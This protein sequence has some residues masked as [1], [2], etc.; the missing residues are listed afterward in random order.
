MR[1]ERGGLL[2]TAM[3]ILALGAVLALA[4]SV[5]L[6]SYARVVASDLALTRA[7]YISYSALNRSVYP[8]LATDPNDSI[9]CADLAEQYTDIPMASGLYTLEGNTFEPAA[10]PLVVADGG[11]QTTLC[12]EGDASGYAAQGRVWIDHEAIDYAQL[13]CAVDNGCPQGCSLSVLVRG[14]SGTVE[15]VHPV[16]SI[17]SQRQCRVRAPARMAEAS[18]V[19]AT[20]S[21]IM[22]DLPVAYALSGTGFW[23]W[24]AGQWMQADS[25][26]AT[27]SALDGL[28][29]QDIWAVGHA[30]VIYHYNGQQWQLHSSGVLTDLY[31]IYC[32]NSV[33]C[34]AVGDAGT[35][36][37]WQG[38]QWVTMASNQDPS[39]PLAI[40]GWSL[41][42][43]HCTSA[44][45]WV[46][47][48]DSQGQA[49]AIAQE[50]DG[51]WQRS[52]NVDP[53]VPVARYR[54]IDC[55]NDYLCYTVGDQ[56]TG[57]FNILRWQGGDWQVDPTL[58][59]SG[60]YSEL[61]AIRCFSSGWCWAVGQAQGNG[62]ILQYDGAS[63]QHAS[64]LHPALS[65]TGRNLVALS[66]RD[67]EHCWAADA[68][69]DIIVHN[70]N[71]WQL[72]ESSMPA[73]V[74]ALTHW[75]YGNQALSF[76][77]YG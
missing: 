50:V 40:N 7:D 74:V 53:G 69:G 49:V 60:D 75:H 52:L 36:L 21:A 48:E 9:L 63:W 70:D 6:T 25:A 10:A 72:L 59:L 71:G 41:L 39:D 67:A 20:E 66:C 45:C 13:N 19:L 47:G 22:R 73:S 58:A 55:V 54:A 28:S 44:T 11:D 14:A 65:L 64:D 35:V 77:A 51:L 2:I 1:A 18:P 26:T 31:G 68:N 27:L 29:Y 15:T 62:V 16:G 32:S 33:L 4:S 76:W 24:Q 8:L 57:N 17:V 37:Q 46:V 43:V 30:G 12:L 3:A 5:R 34:Y 42:A 61:H 23:Q 38:A 56:T